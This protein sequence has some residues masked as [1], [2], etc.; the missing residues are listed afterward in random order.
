MYHFVNAGLYNGIFV[1]QD[2]ETR[3]LWNHITGEVM[4]GE[5]AGRK[6]P[7]SN[8]LQVNVKQALSLDPKIAVAISSRPYSGAPRKTDPGKA[9]AAL[10]PRFVGTLGTEDTRRPRMDMGL[11]VWSG[12]IRRYYP[13][14]IIRHRG[15]A[16]IDSIGNRKVLIYI[17]PEMFVPAALFVDSNTA[18]LQGKEIRL[19]SGAVLRS[20]VL[21]GRDGK[22]VP[23]ER[24]QQ[25]FT[26][27]YG[28][29]LTFP[30]SE[31]FGQ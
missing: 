27:W 19:D 24:P 29:A 28:F 10:L 22:P 4:Y 3:T 23:A 15:E 31:V 11:G 14:E 6:L 30:E 26:R 7:I 25:I 5:L 16:M 1:M 12:G 20:G 18:K 2:T 9:D 8:L 13:M 17:D 21:V